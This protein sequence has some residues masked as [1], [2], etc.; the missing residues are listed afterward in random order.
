MTPCSSYPLQC[1]LWLTIFFNVVFTHYPCETK[2]YIDARSLCRNFVLLYRQLSAVVH[3]TGEDLV[4]DQP[5]KKVDDKYLSFLSFI[6]SVWKPGPQLTLQVYIKLTTDRLPTLPCKC[7]WS[8]VLSLQLSCSYVVRLLQ[9][10]N[11]ENPY[12]SVVITSNYH[13]G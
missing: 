6:E 8:T 5:R 2:S 3:P 9:F 11:C 10:L 7:Q 12:M 13:F 4:E 1:S